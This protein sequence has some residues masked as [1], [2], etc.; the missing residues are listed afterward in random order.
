MMWKPEIDEALQPL[1]ERFPYL[2]EG[3]HIGL[4]LPTGWISRL[5]ALCEEIDAMLSPEQRTAEFVHFVQLKEKFGTARIYIEGDFEE[6]GGVTVWENGQLVADPHANGST[7][8]DRLQRACRQAEAETA[9]LCAGCGEP[10]EQRNLGGYLLVLCEQHYED[11]RRE[12]P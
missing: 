12:T 4:F 6:H 2:F 3:Q 5:T 8:Q 9:Q 1:A 7:L 10:A 11:R